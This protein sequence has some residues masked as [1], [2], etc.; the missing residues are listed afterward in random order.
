[1]SESSI[2]NCPKCG[3]QISVS[4][5][6]CGQTVGC[7]HCS[8]HL[9]LQVAQ[10]S[11]SDMSL[12][13]SLPQ[14]QSLNAGIEV[15]SEFEIKTKSRSKRKIRSRRKKYQA[16]RRGHDIS[17]SGPGLFQVDIVG[18]S[19]YQDAL[20][21]LCG[22]KSRDSADLI[23][24]VSLICEENNPQ[25][26]NA[27]RVDVGKFTVGYLDRVNA[28]EFRQRLIEAGFAGSTALCRARIV[29]GW[30]RSDED[31]GYFGVKLDLP[32]E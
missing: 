30:Y 6:I 14:A 12:P 8:E 5:E 16:L 27:V 31:Q 19:H 25:D 29:G 21:F 24:L 15:G 13:T 26:H 4:V 3:G 2:V 17:L 32:I 20:E 9:V 23:V 18:E 28:Q 7:P 22:G 1:M 10:E 11:S